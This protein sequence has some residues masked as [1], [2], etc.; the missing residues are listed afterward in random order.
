VAFSIKPN[1]KKADESDEEAT[2]RIMGELE[3]E[4]VAKIAA[5]HK[6][7]QEGDVEGAKKIFYEKEPKLYQ[8]SE[9]A[10]EH[11]TKVN[12][13]K[14]VSPRATRQAKQ[15]AAFKQRAA[16]SREHMLRREGLLAR[17]DVASSLGIKDVGDITQFSLNGIQNIVN[18]FPQWGELGQ[19]K[20]LS[21]DEI[22]AKLPD[23]K[24]N[25]DLV[26]FVAET[27]DIDTDKLSQDAAEALAAASLIFSASLSAVDEKV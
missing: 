4:V 25:A 3:R 19:V 13:P 12:K 27:G 5:Y 18:T 8:D 6:A 21:V 22:E 7:K 10:T 14:R 1:V 16:Q 9:E 24:T 23:A 20:D 17:N 2:A 11:F 26:Q 15:A